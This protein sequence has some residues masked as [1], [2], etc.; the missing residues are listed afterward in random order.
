MIRSAQ[1]K[2]KGDL[3]ESN[4]EELK[5]DF[6]SLTGSFTMKDAVMTN[7]DLAMAAP[8]IRLAGKGTANIVV[9]SLSGQGDANDESLKGVDIPLTI[10][11]TFQEPKFGIDTK[12]LLEGKLKGETDKAKEK[13]KEGLFKKLGI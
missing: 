2:L 12:A 3:S 6:T 7:P 4:K 11:G 1:Q 13:L 9:G 5:T 10:K 8:L